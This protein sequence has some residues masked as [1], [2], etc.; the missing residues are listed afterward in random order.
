M[1]GPPNAKHGDQPGADLAV[2]RNS[3][4]AL[5]TH[6]GASGFRVEKAVGMFCCIF[7]EIA[8]VAQQHLGR[9]DPNSLER[10]A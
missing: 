3:G 6:N 8:Q 7:R 2:G 4:L 1:I 10:K 9:R 5:E